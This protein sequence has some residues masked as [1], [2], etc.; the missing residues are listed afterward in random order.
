[1]TGN[2]TQTH[3]YNWWSPDGVNMVPVSTANPL[4]VN[5]TVTATAET[6]AVATAA[7]PTYTEGSTDSLS[8]DLSGNLRVTGSISASTTA[9]ASSTP[10]SY[11]AG[12]QPLS[13]DLSGHLR[14]V[15]EIDQSTP[16]STNA[17]D[18]TNFPVTVD[19]NT[20]NATASTPRVVLASN[21]PTVAVSA[22]SLPLP[23]GASTS[24]LQTTGNTSLATI[25]SSVGATGSAV[26]ADASYT[27]VLAQTALPTATTAGNQVGA[28]AD[29]YGRQIVRSA[30]R[31]LLGTVSINTTGTSG[32]LLAAQGANVFSD[33]YRL[34]IA[35]SS[36][37]AVL[38][39][40]SDGTNTYPFEVPANG[41]VGFS[42]PAS[43][44]TPAATANTAWTYTVAT[45]TTTIYIH[46]QYIL[47]H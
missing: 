36:A 46:G 2:T 19:T 47:N 10:P 42:G 5:A 20:G 15:S 33:F 27:G 8:M 3:T 39:S 34:V 29:I 7:P 28:L 1:M 22:A 32:T 16:G 43:D 44:A 41:T 23:S 37:T 25:A 40:I 35:N 38:V 17:V 14:C 24:A 26:P 12:S 13:Q 31:N 6:V 4:P 9:N 30:P 45:G 21:Q 18:A 11:S